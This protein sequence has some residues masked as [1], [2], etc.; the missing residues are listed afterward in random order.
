MSLT[1][2]SSWLLH[3]YQI[4]LAAALFVSVDAIVVSFLLGCSQKK[5][6]SKNVV[7]VSGRFSLSHMFLAFFGYLIA[8][9]MGGWLSKNAFLVLS[10]IFLIIAIRSLVYAFKTKIQRRSDLKLSGGVLDLIALATASDSLLFGV[11]SCAVSTP[12]LVTC[13]ILGL[14]TFSLTSL[15]FLV[16]TVFLNTGII[17]E[18]YGEK[19]ISK[20]RVQRR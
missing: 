9:P 10:L 17:I 4:V 7:R 14:V 15:A 11:A 19:I 6:S 20:K 18:R 2:P 3:P 5:L 12:I 13:A 1:V 8:A 16:G